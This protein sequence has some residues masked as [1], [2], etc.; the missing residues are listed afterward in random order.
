MEWLVD[1][2][3]YRRIVPP[4]EIAAM[5]ANWFEADDGSQVHLSVDEEHQP[6]RRAHVAVEIDD[7]AATS[8]RLQDRGDDFRTSETPQL[9]VI[10][11]RDPAGNR[12][13]LRAAPRA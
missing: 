11:C 6:A 8:E 10:F 3:G 12:W 1:V 5:G 13:E 4:A 9:T 7:A 2:L